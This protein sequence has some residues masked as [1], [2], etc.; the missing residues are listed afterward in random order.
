MYPY[1]ADLLEALQQIAFRW[2]SDMPETSKDRIKFLKTDFEFLHIFL[3]LQSFTDLSYMLDVTHKVEALF[4]DAAVDLK[5]VNKIQ[6]VDRVTSRILEKILITKMEIRAID[7]DLSSNGGIHT[8]K[9]VMEFIDTVTKN[10]DDLFGG[11]KEELGDVCHELKLLRNFV[12][13]VSDRSIEPKSQHNDFFTHVLVVVGQAATIAWLYFSSN[14]RKN[15]VMNILLSDH[16]HMKIKPIQ[17]GVRRIYIDVLQAVTPIMQYPIVQIENAADCV[18]GFVETL[19]H[20]LKELP[21]ICN[22]SGIVASTA[23]LEEMLGILI[24]NLLC[25]SIQDLEFHLQ[26]IDTVVIDSGLLVY[27]LYEDVVTLD[28]SGTVE[29]IK[30]LIYHIIRNKFQSNLPR[31]HGIGYVDI[32][33]NNLEEFPN[34]YPVALAYVKTQLQTIQ[35]ELKKLQPFLS[36]VA[37]ER[38]NKYGKLQPSV[39]LLIGKAYEVEYVVH[40]CV[41]N[42]VPDWCL[43]L[44]L[45]DLIKEIRAELAKIQIIVVDS[46]SHDTMDTDTSHTSSGLV[47]TQRIDDEIVGFENEIET[48]RQQLT[49]GCKRRDTIS[50]VGMPGAGKTALAN[51]LYFDE[52][53]VFHFQVRARC[54]VSSLYS[55]RELL[56]SILETL[57][58]SNDETSPV[59]KDTNDLADMLRKFLHTRRYLILIDGVPDDRVWD[60][61]ESCF[62]DDNNGSRILLTTRHY[63]VA[64]D[65]R[66]VSE[67]LC[68]PLLDNDDSWMLLKRK[69]FGEGR[70]SPLHEK[71]GPKIAG[72]CGGL[73]LSIVFLASILARMEKT[74]ECWKKVA[75]SLGSEILCYPENIIEQSY[76]NLPYHLKSCFLYF[77]MF[78]DHEEINIP[79]LTL[80]WIGEGFVKD[81]D[82]MSLEGIAEGYLKNLVESNLV[83]LAKRS[84]G[85]NVKECRIH[86]ILFH[87]CK[88]RAHKENFIQ[89]IQRSQRDVYS[90]KKLDQHRLALYAEVDDLVKWSSS[91][92]FVSSVLF[93]EANTNVPSSI[94]EDSNIFHSFKFLKVLDLEFTVIDSFPTDMVYLRYFAAQTSQESIT[95]SIDQLW[96]LETLI[97]NRM[98]GYL[99]VPITIWK[100]TKLRHLHISPY[101]TSEELPEDSSELYDLATFSTPYFS[102][103]EDAQLM[104][105][106]TPNIRD[107]RCK[108]KGL[109]SGQFPVLDFPTQLEVLDIFGDQPVEVLS[110]LV[111]ISASN[112][113]KLKVSFFRLGFQHLSNISQ[114]R[115]L[116]ALELNFVEFEAEEWEVRRDEFS[117]LKVL[118][119][120]NCLSLKEWTVSDDAFPNLEHLSLH[121]CLLLTE[122]PSCF[123]D[124]CSLKYIEVDNCNKSVVKSATEIQ[125]TQQGYQNNDFELVIKDHNSGFWRAPESVDE[126]LDSPQS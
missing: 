61:L 81:D 18:A 105:T 57:P 29:D 75:R 10:L 34:R 64:R 115:N 38:H 98:E 102:C 84:C 12:C 82:H 3:T 69:V 112:L 70:C 88:T 24:K 26:D 68:L 47:R 41:S 20:N 80:L 110:Y 120:V 51:R 60:D 39:T 44:W 67:P 78:S 71:L 62:C 85:G 125:E 113:K 104:L 23:V 36:S 35:T 72:K 103:V 65:A 16:L 49:R 31:I 109:S 108:F 119:L 97:V 13:F 15:E 92:S 83:M 114:L 53:I 76:Q 21:T 9:F 122:I 7:L 8:P 100:M 42:E 89:R 107:L 116:Q 17:P 79:K 63:N 48:L 11:S 46:A 73:P 123:G 59:S 101:F 56:L 37:S 124:I 40:G 4:Q 19:Q 52:S 32:L 27:S 30:T 54:Y 86:D 45:F 93:R 99:S 118:K 6:H 94:S 66:S 58:I 5:K 95:S 96:N 43:K 91:C 77:G 117:Q 90:P 106:K 55:R 87:F 22:T 121:C 1:K 126:F 74:E 50:I 111:C 14:G 25:L 33:L 2:D 28:F